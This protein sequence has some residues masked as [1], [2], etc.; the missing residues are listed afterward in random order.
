MYLVTIRDPNPLQDIN[1]EILNRL[2]NNNPNVGIIDWWAAS[3]GHREYL[4]DDGTHPT[5]VGNEVL[6]NLYKQALCGQ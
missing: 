4:V 3:E 1:N 6:A 2:A 5:N